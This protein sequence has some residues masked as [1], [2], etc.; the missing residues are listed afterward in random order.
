ML[1]RPA[2]PAD[3]PNILPM[4]R[5][6][7]A[8]HAAMDPQRYDFLPDIVDRYARWLPERAIDPRSVLLVGEEKEKAGALAGFLIATIET[9]IPIYHTTEFG[10]IHDLWVEPHARRSGLASM[11]T[12]AALARFKELGI[13]QVRL[14]TATHNDTARALFERQGL[15]VSNIDMVHT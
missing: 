11:L 1:V 7:C 6:I 14:E 2:T 15:R 5:A 3:M 13:N 10:F 12:S 8:M 9:N 4:V